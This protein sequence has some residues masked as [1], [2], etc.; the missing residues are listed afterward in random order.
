MFAISAS[1]RSE[2]R[3]IS[4]CARMNSP[5]PFQT[6]S[7]R[8]LLFDTLH[9]QAAVDRVD[10]SRDV[11]GLVLEQERN[12]ARDL[13]RPSEPAQRDLLD[14]RVESSLWHLL[15]HLGS[16]ESRRDDVHGDAAARHL[17]REALAE[18]DQT[19]L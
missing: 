2:R 13:L 15:H 11:A 4:R 3:A 14:D 8:S 7:P 17:E 6:A 19:G 16:D 12:D 10:G 1:C 9:V 18:P 5:T